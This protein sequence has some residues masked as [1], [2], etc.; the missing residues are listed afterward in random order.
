MKVIITG[1]T[2]LIG[3]ALTRELRARHHNVAILTR[4]LTGQPDE[5]LWNPDK[6]EIDRNVFDGADA[7]VHLAGASIGKRWTEKYKQQL[8]SS[9]IRSANFLLESAQHNNIQFQVFIS[10]SGS[11]F[12]GTYTSEQLLSEEDPLQ[13][14]DFLSDL[15]AAW[16]NA[17]QTF[18]T[19]AKRTVLMR[20]GMVLANEGGSLP[21]LKKLTKFNLSSPAGSGK[22]WMNWIH[23]QDLVNLYIF[24]LENNGVKGPINAV[25]APETNARFMK[26]LAETEGKMFLKLPVPSF[27]LKTVVGEMSD[28]LLEGTR[29]SNK[30]IKNAGFSFTYENLKDA[31]KDLR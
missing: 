15:S 18:D 3:K 12:Y 29:L 7:L 20:T 27:L 21:L 23:L 22:Q 2:G 4:R 9:R 10:A 5:Y 1:G 25:A 24:A 13:Q 6:K 11:N 16:E 19:I 30:K 31:L 17:G 28:L 14:H 8:Y 26:T